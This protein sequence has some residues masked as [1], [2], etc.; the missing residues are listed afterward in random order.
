ME[1]VMHAGTIPGF[2]DGQFAPFWEITFGEDDRA[3]RNVYDLLVKIANDPD[4]QY[5]PRVLAIMSLSEKKAPDMEKSLRPLIIPPRAELQGEWRVYFE[6]RTED[7]L[8]EDLIQRSRDLALSGYARY[9]LAK[10]GHSR[11]VLAKIEEMKRWIRDNRAVIDEKG[12]FL[13]IFG[14]RRLEQEFSR[15]LF[16]DI[17]Y[18]YQQLDDFENAR[19]WYTRLLKS[20]PDSFAVSNTHYNLACL[21]SLQNETALAMH[22]L[23]R[24]IDTGFLDFSWMD[25][26]RDLD[27][28]RNLPEFAELK[29]RV[30]APMDSETEVPEGR[31]PE[32]EQL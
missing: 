23:Q 26:D 29:A 11:H 9:S 15:N 22:H 19:V 10:A 31:D 30:L 12:M 8:D 20:F 2:Y 3:G 18:E 17:G 5:I 4:F 14:R 16:F 21:Y 1:G 7:V 6:Q 25:K 13:Q 24:S 27:N 28:I 32:N